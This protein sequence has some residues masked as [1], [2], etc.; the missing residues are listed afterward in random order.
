[1]KTGN[2]DIETVVKQ[3]VH[4]G[5]QL[6]GDDFIGYKF[7]KGNSIFW[8]S[9]IYNLYQNDHDVA[10]ILNKA[11]LLQNNIETLEYDSNVWKFY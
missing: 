3:A 9:L 8:N 11:W 10:N 2:I 6:M 1:M 5:E 4:Y 7:V